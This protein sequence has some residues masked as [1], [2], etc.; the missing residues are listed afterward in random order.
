MVEQAIEQ[1]PDVLDTTP[2]VGD[3]FLGKPAGIVLPKG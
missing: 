2:K 3:P 1:L